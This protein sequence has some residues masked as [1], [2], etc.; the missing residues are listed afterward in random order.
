MIGVERS[1]AVYT[2][3]AHG[4]SGSWALEGS[5]AYSGLLPRENPLRGFAISA[6]TQVG[7]RFE[8]TPGAPDIKRGLFR[9]TFG[10][11]AAR[12]VGARRALF[13]AVRAERVALGAGSFPA[14]ELRYVGG[15]EGLRGHPDRAFGGNRLLVA[16]VEHRWLADETGGRTYLFFDAAR[17]TLDGTLQ[18]GAADPA[19]GPLAR[20]V[21]SNGWDFGY[22]AGLRTRAAAGTV[23]IELGMRPGAAVREAQL[24]IHYASTW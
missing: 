19:V 22:G 8:E 15:N 13:A 21:L 10:V 4:S 9:G 24:H 18:A 2:G 7:R 16:T 14:E 5:G 1:G 3:P 12:P 20:T 23:G 17:H 6:T 11:E